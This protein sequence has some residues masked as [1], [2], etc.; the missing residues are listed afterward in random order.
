MK[1]F[2]SSSDVPGVAFSLWTSWWRQKFKISFML[3]I[4]QIYRRIFRKDLSLICFKIQRSPTYSLQK[5]HWSV[6][7]PVYYT[8]EHLHL[9]VAEMTLIN[10]SSCFNIQVRIYILKFEKL[11][12]SLIIQCRML[13]IWDKDTSAQNFIGSWVNWW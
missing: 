6:T 11:H 3:L 9:T 2:T 5:W 8:S 4:N 12:W 13:R 10:D 7:N 1:S